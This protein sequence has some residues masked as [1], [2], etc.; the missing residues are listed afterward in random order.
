MDLIITKLNADFPKF[1]LLKILQHKLWL[2]DHEV[3]GL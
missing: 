1:V 3:E 2:F